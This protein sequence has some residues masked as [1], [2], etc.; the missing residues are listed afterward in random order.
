M[1]NRPIGVTVL[2][3]LAGVLAVLAGIATLRF[4]GLFPFL[5]PLDI[6]IFNL[7]YALMYGL[8]AWVWAWLA[9]MLWRV[10]PSAWMFLAVITVFNL[11]IDF[12][13]MITGGDWYDVNVSVI[14]N[15]LILLYVILP[16]TRRAF[17][18]Q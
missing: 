8:L 15:A 4:L 10:D 1:N 11:T 6:R 7:W 2:A 5:G 12:V 17:G 18:Q 13:I 16:G 14:L 9:Q 3:I